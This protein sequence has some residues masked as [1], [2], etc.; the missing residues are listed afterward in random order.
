MKKSTFAKKASPVRRIITGY[1]IYLLLFPA[2]ALIASFICYNTKDPTAK[3]QLF[4]LISLLASAAI[5]GLING[6]MCGKDNFTSAIIS[7]ALAALTLF[8][9]GLIAGGKASALLMNAGCYLPVALICSYL[10]IARKKKQ[11]FKVRR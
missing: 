8:P 3:I 2:L 1:L 6:R 7:C 11:K 10:A 5:G 9:L 4:S